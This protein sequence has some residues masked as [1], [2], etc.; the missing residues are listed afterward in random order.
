MTALL[1]ALAPLQEPEYPARFAATGPLSGTQYRYRLDLPRGSACF[2]LRPYSRRLQYE[3]EV[4]S[5]LRWLARTQKTDGSWDPGGEPFRA[6]VTGLALLAFLQAGHIHT[7]IHWYDGISFG[8]GVRNALQ[9]ILSRQGL[10]GSFVSGRSST[11]L[12]FHSICTLAISEAYGLS[13]SVLLREPAERALQYLLA[14]WT[15]EE[16]P[17]VTGWAVLALQS[18]R[19]W[20]FPVKDGVPAAAR[21]SDAS[22]GIAIVARLFVDQKKSD[23]R[24]LDS[25]DL[26]LTHP[27]RWKPD[28]M[29]FHSWHWNTMALFEFD[30]PSGPR[31]K[32]WANPVFQAILSHQ[33]PDG[34]WDPLDRWCVD[35]GRTYATAVNAL[36]LQTSRRFIFIFGG[37]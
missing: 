21:V 34:S 35:G 30:G 33:R 16:D 28:V 29:D 5:A 26:L 17:S 8:H 24:L 19:M 11:S 12:A 31:W 2:P 9:W 6:G 3:K 25:C 32:A 37:R 15:G 7:C 14:T 18:A 27:P 36:T 23:P 13:G 1:L 20:D 22:P 4:T 10:D